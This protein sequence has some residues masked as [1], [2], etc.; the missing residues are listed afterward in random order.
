[1]RTGESVVSTVGR[2]W[3]QPRRLPAGESAP[4]GAQRD[5]SRIPVTA[6]APFDPARPTDGEPWLSVIVPT[7]NEA[8]NIAAAL[9]RA[10][11]PGAELVVV[12]GG[13]SDGTVTVARRYADVVLTGQ[14]GRAAQMNAGAAAARGEVLLFL[15][16]DTLLPWGYAE[17]VRVAMMNPRT[18]GGRFDV[19][20]DGRGPLYACIGVLINV[21]SRVSRVATGD[22]AMFVRR[23]D[24]QRLGGYPELPL[25]ED[26]ALSRALKRVGSIACLRS[27]VITSARRWR[28]H[29]VL[30]TV[31]LMWALR[32]LYYFGASPRL[33]RRVYPDHDAARG[34]HSNSSPDRVVRKGQSR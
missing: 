34:R 8:S 16:A 28:E 17:Q 14:R 32:L 2:L 29:G 1:M 23:A 11:C 31:L 27:R 12:D 25:M 6:S 13:S 19:H 20:L 10:A 33:L 21:R 18:V 9:R 22:Q 30:R 7:V 24:F 15:H 26:L 3:W 4:G 5:S